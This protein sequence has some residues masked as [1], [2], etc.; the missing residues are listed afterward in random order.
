MRILLFRS[1]LSPPVF[2]CVAQT[3]VEEAQRRTSTVEDSFRL[4]AQSANRSGRGRT[5]DYIMQPCQ[6]FGG[7]R[8]SWLDE[9]DS[10]CHFESDAA[11]QVDGASAESTL[12][13]R[14]FVAES[15]EE[16]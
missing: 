9:M 15:I 2:F 16:G 5:E 11:S 12:V 1:G 3:C 7:E 4:Q 6:P 13:A 10:E 8:R 14:L